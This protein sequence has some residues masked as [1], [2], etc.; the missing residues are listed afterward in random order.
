MNDELLVNGRAYDWGILSVRCSLLPTPF[1]GI[2]KVEYDEKQTITGNY[3]RG[4][5]M[6]SKGY[7]NVEPTASISL[8][9]E[10]IMRL[11]RISPSGKLRDLPTCDIVISFLHADPAL[12]T[13]TILAGVDFTN[14]PMSL[15]QND[16]EFVSDLELH[17]ADI[18]SDSRVGVFPTAKIPF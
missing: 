3:G 14:Q 8:T 6:T 4:N 2:K 16:P 5:K 18:I 13:H 9:M 7:G 17:V 15:N 12:T 11:V 1:Y 10:E